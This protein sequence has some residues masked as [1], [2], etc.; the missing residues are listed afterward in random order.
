V[1]VFLVEGDDVTA[2]DGILLAGAPGDT[3]YRITHRSG[4]GT[5][6]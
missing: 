2:G 3:D 6:P 5:V 1:R 4:Q